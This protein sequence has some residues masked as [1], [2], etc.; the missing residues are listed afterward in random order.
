L[1]ALAVMAAPVLASPVALAPMLAGQFQ[2]G[3]GVDARFLKVADD[4]QQ[5]SVLWNQE[6]KT[7]GSGAP[8]GGYGWGTGLWGI[9]D[10][11]TANSNPT[12][13][14]IE[15]SWSGR[16]AQIAWGDAEYIKSYGS[17]WGNVEPLF[18][19][20]DGQDNWSSSF[21]GYIRISEA[22]LYNFSVLYD[23]GFFFKLHGAGNTL[24][25]SEDFLNPRDRL[26]FDSNLLLD[27]GLYAFDLGAYDR[28]EAGVVEL[29]WSRGGGAWAIV[30]TTELVAFDAV[31]AVPEP[32]SGALMAGGL[33]MLAAV[34]ARH[35]RRC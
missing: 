3:N 35:R 4:W 20:V 5:S 1:L 22:G 10:W 11:R 15:S 8:I 29:S 26:G 32:G 17:T 21:S 9:A 18:K 28:H 12:A 30:P 33:L 13:G 23:D 34:S 16:V 24:E 31:R 7:Y 25:I 27:V 14:M 19:L 2:D 6:E